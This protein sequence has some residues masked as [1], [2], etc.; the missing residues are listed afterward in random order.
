MISLPASLVAGAAAGWKARGAR[1]RAMIPSSISAA[2][3]AA[4]LGGVGGADIERR[5]GGKRRSRGVGLTLLRGSRCRAGLKAGLP[6][7]LAL[8]LG[9]G[10]GLGLTQLLA[11][12]AAAEQARPPTEKSVA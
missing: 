4:G 12:V 5:G 6:Q 2:T 1:L 10:L 11:V 7:L 8:G 9:L 3:S